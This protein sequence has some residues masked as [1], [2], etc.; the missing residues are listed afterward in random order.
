MNIIKIL[1]KK[2]NLQW[3]NAIIVGIYTKISYN[4]VQFLRKEVSVYKSFFFH[5]IF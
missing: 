2:T 5:A 1:K 3:L 4:W